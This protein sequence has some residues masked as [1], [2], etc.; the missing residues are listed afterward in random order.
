M[1]LGEE[2]ELGRH[3]EV[4]CLALDRDVGEGHPGHLDVEKVTVDFFSSSHEDTLH[5]KFSCPYLIFLHQTL[6]TSTHR[7]IY[8]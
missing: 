8:F 3:S 6:A 1:L 2:A 5:N 7:F 4:G